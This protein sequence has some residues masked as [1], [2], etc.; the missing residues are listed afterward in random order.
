MFKIPTKLET[1]L[2]RRSAD[3]DTSRPFNKSERIAV[4]SQQNRSSTVSCLHRCRRPADVTRFVATIIVDSIEGVSA[5]WPRPHVAQKR[6]EIALPFSTD[7]NST[8]AIIRVLRIVRIVAASFHTCP[9]NVFGGLSAAMGSM[10][11]RPSFH[12]VSWK[13][14]RSCISREAATTTRAIHS[15]ILAQKMKAAAGNIQQLSGWKA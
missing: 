14:S 4:M 12:G 8:A 2:Q 1:L 9:N 7:P 15:E 3:A 5:R 13:K 10:V 11:R 6:H